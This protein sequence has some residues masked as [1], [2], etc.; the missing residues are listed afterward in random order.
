M[1]EHFTIEQ[2]AIQFQVSPTQLKK[3]FRNVYGNSLYSYVR[4]QKMLS[5]ARLLQ[6]TD[7]TILD[8][9]GECGYD[10]GS[11]FYKAFRS[12]MGVSTRDFRNNKNL[13]IESVRLE[14]KKHI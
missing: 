13:P 5:A 11:K 14:R 8:I 7:R 1:S 2:L 9:A 12:V 6:D 4:T 3:S 10:N